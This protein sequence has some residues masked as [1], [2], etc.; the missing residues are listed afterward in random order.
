[1]IAVAAKSQTE[2]DGWYILDNRNVCVLWCGG[3][4]NLTTD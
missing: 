1:M 4:S 2:H 3:T